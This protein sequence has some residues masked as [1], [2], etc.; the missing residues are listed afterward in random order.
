MNAT[1][2]WMVSTRS[3]LTAAG[4]LTVAFAEYCLRNANRS[5]AKDEASLN[6]EEGSWW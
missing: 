2:S 4:I 3:V 5:T 1:H 6:D